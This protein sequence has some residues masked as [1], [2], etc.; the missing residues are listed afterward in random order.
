MSS[1]DSG[2]TDVSPRSVF[3]RTGKKQRTAAIVTFDHGTQQPE[4]C[5]RD[6]GECDDRDC[7]GGDHV[8]H[9]RI[10]ERPPARQDERGDDRGSTPENEA[11]ERLLEGDPC[12]ASSLSRSSTSA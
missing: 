2:S 5:V 6:R 7:V 11:A 10:P 4:P 9:Q 3:T 1:I 8:R 12:A